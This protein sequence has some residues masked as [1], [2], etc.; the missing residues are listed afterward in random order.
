MIKIKY[1]IL[2]ALLII[3]SCEKYIEQLSISNSIKDH[4][5][6]IKFGSMYFAYNIIQNNKYIAVVKGRY[7]NKNTINVYNRRYELLYELRHPIGSGIGSSFSLNNNNL[8]SRIE[9]YNIDSMILFDLKT[10]SYI[11]IKIPNTSENNIVIHDVHINSK[12]I[13]AG[14]IYD[15]NGSVFVFDLNG[16]FIKKIKPKDGD[17]GFG[18]GIRSSDESIIIDNFYDN[19]KYVYNMD[20]ELK[21]ILDF[22][23]ILPKK[24][25][26]YDGDYVVI[27]NK[28]II[29]SE[30]ERYGSYLEDGFYLVR[31]FFGELFKSRQRAYFIIYNLESQDVNIFNDDKYDGNLKISSSDSNNYYVISDSQHIFAYD[32]YKGLVSKIEIP[33]ELKPYNYN[34]DNISIYKSIIGYSSYNDYVQFYDIND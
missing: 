12:Y 26:F 23:D 29:T 2:L 22:N 3:L 10:E 6:D 4:N 8:L 9:I 21:T 5:L 33:N 19:K 34:E 25:K 31:A 17:K 28:L 13:F 14:S 7:S 20:L 27:D 32:I 15:G 24:T 30:R 1:I 11:N 16:V 18:Y